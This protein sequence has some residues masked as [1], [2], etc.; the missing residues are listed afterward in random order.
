MHRINRET[1]EDIVVLYVEDE[2]LIRK[3]VEY[4]LSKY[5]KKIYIASNGEEALEIYNN[6]KPDIV[7]TDIQMPKMNGIEMLKVM[8]PKTI[9]V[10]ITTAH[11]DMD[12]FLDAVELKVDKFLVKPLNLIEIIENIQTLVSRTRLQQR[13][14]ENNKLL[15]IIDEN[16]LI[17]ITDKNGLIVDA[18][19]A[20]CDL[21]EYSKD[22]L[23]GN[24]HSIIKHE[25]NKDDFYK[26][27]WSIINKGEVYKTEI[28]NRKKS[29][30]VF[31]A[32]LT[33]TPL[34]HEGKI[35]NYIAIRQDVTNKKK[36]EQLAI[37]DEMTKLYNRRYL[38]EVIEKEIRRIKREN[39]T[40]SFVTIDIDY[41]KRYN[42]F[43]G[44]PEGD[45]VLLKVANILKESA[46]RA[47]DYIFRMGGE[48]FGIIFSDTNK[49]KSL[50][51]MEEIVKAV[52]DLKIEHKGSVCSPYLT[53]SA[54]L[55][56]QSSQ[57]LESFKKTYK[58][59]DEALYLAKKNGKNQ[60]VLSDF[61]K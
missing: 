61:S 30:D 56:V 6:I 55:V 43:Y 11:S 16:V 23:L 25:D 34:I 44:H 9:P 8:N 7:I 10:I 50:A 57:Y 2:K 17:T 53:I 40:L 46:K 20:F 41:F 58:Y 48:E 15:E 52:C 38:N 32:K 22:E 28:K 21:V 60:V 26:S 47:T 59:S 19:D 33:I 35:E 1:L 5:L 13:L 54:G 31:W 12:Y 4:Y 45:V 51:F 42:D 3:E 14:I 37:H 18:S 29:K 24:T 27:M 36:L 49:E 39:S